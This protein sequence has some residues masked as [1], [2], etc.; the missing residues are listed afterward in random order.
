MILLNPRSLTRPYPDA[1][2]A[3]VMRKTIE[4]FETKGKDKLPQG[5]LPRARLVRRLPR[6]REARAHL[7]DHVARRPAT[8]AP[9]A[10]WDTWRI[11]EFAEILG[12]YGLQYWYTWQ[13]S[14]LGL[15]PIWMSQQRGGEAA[16]RAALLEDGGIFAF[17][18]SE[19]GARRRHLLDRHGADARRRRPLRRERP[20]VLH[21]QRQRGGD[22]LDVRQASRRHATT[23]SSSPP[24]RGTPTL[25]AGQERRRE[26]ELRLRV[27][28][29]RLPGRARPTS[30]T[31]AAT[32]GTPRSTPSTSASTTSAG[33]RSASAPTPSTRR[34]RH[35]A[36]R[37]P[38]QDARHRLPARAADVHR[39][40]LP[41]GRDEALRA[42]R[43]RLHARRRRPRTAATSSTTRW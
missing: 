15:G 30:C 7:R 43:R 24:T 33:R 12:F 31:A 4:F 28:A 2:S 17:G 23:T 32:P 22:R 37:A 3:E 20:Q 13:V 11:C 29:P 16:R 42:A 39:R 36:N 9:D 25:P 41:A 18:L 10:R 8:G 35:A 34:S 21:R 6:V 14:V 19:S 27:R 40:L 5:G 26:P 1:R 38:L